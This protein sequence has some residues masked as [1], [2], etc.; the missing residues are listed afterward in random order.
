MISFPEPQRYAQLEC[1]VHYYGFLETGKLVNIRK[2][3]L[4]KKIALSP[5]DKNS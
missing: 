3:K 5:G 1:L 2:S 4:E